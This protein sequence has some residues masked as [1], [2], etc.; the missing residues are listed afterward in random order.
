MKEELRKLKLGKS[1]EDE[2]IESNI[3]KKVVKKELRKLKKQIEELQ[4]KIEKN[5]QDLG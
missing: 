3:G 1:E 5:G 2:D 4:H